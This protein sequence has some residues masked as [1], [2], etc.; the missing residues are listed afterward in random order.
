MRLANLSPEALERLVVGREPPAETRND[1][2]RAT[3]V[4]WQRQVDLTLGAR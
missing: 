3:Y 2:V 4:P 1:L